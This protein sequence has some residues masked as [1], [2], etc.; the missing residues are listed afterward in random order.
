MIQ[1]SLRL[2][3][4]AWLGLGTGLAATASA[5]PAAPS[6]ASQP[7]P[8]L[9][10]AAR[11][12]A[13]L[14][15]A[16]Q[17]YIFERSA[18]SYR[19]EADGT[20][21]S[22]AEVRIR[23][24][25]ETG[26]QQLG[27]LLFTYVA[28]RN[29]LE[30][31]YLRVRRPDGSITAGS[32]DLIQ[33][34]PVPAAAQ[35]PLYSDV[36]MLHVTV[37]SFG[38]GDVLEYRLIDHLETPET[39]NR[40][41]FANAFEQQAVVLEESIEVDLPADEWINIYLAEG[42]EPEIREARG[43]RIYRWT[44][45]NETPG[46]AGAAVESLTGYDIELSNFRD[47]QEVGAWYTGLEGDRAS[48][49]REI[50]HQ[51]EVLVA[52]LTDDR[53]RIEAIYN[54]VATELRYLALL[55]GVGR[56]QPHP[57]AEV[58]DNGYGDC[59]DK[60]TL[61]AALLEA[62]GYRASPVLIGSLGEPT[63]EVPSLE[64]FDHMITAVALG[65]D[66]LLLDS[67]QSLPFGYLDPSL[68][69]KQALLMPQGEAA[70]LITVPEHL[71]FAT[72]RDF[73][74]VGE[75]DDT[76]TLSAAVEHSFRG[77]EEAY[78]RATLLALPR[79]EW[80]NLVLGLNAGM[81]LTG[82]VSEL[83][84]TEPTAIGEPLTLSYTLKRSGMLHRYR[85]NQTLDLPR[86]PIDFTAVPDDAAAAEEP[87]ELGE[88]LSA[89]SR[90]ELTLPAGFEAR[91]PVAVAIDN[92]FAAYTSRYSADGS[93]LVAER[94]AVL[95]Q[96]QLPPEHFRE[97]TALRKTAQ[98]DAEQTFNLR[99][100]QGAPVAAEA[101]DAAALH[102]AATSAAKAGD[103][104][105]A[106]ELFSRLVELEPE[107]ATAW[108]DLG[109][110]LVLAGEVEK[111]VGA[112]RRQIE[113]DP[114]HERVHSN[115]GWALE[116]A[117]DP[118]AAEAA[119][120]AQL[121]RYPLNHYANAHLGELLDEQERCADAVP[122]LENALSIESDDHE[123]RMRLG[124][125]Q[126]RL[127]RRQEGVATL[128]PLAASSEVWA[129]HSAGYEALEHDAVDTA[130]RLLRRAIELDPD[131]DFAFNNLGRALLHQGRFD[132]AEAALRRQIEIVPTDRW[133]HLNLAR[134]LVQQGKLPPAIA[135]ARRHLEIVPDDT[136]ALSGLA[137]ALWG[138]RQ[139]DEAT[140]TLRRLLELEPEHPV[141]YTM[142]GN[143][144]FETNDF[145]EAA[146]ALEKALALNAED[147]P[148]NNML[149]I[150]YARQERYTEA[151]PLLEKARALMGE[152][153]TDQDMLDHVREKAGSE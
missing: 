115:L 132:E 58:L 53:A 18:R 8:E 49:T 145:D 17:P 33:D 141:A 65:D 47:W 3:T 153:F 90:I 125:C 86:P 44:G 66:R 40:Y 85:Q 43:R 130:I 2:L 143:I 62:A 103:H 39:P 138:N 54:Y 152:H 24:H 109:R 21:R 30:L 124:R 36:R 87:M 111:G 112:F 134:S 14:A 13:E 77:D 63:E 129:V 102:E 35:F 93:K 31:D 50:R 52:G 136:E 73:S 22:V 61:L 27:Q 144:L 150:I 118:Q 78:L 5:Q 84:I 107:H 121:E 108:H 32:A 126:L 74:L 106:V 88:L 46:G 148:A 113:G 135:A 25:N 34:L 105:T 117:G 75:I 28:G 97:W 100:S 64:G 149:G 104:A 11:V 114:F 4:I 133:A 140:G 16:S 9:A 29:R 10:D 12:Q 146:G 99:R 6:H 116:K 60:H 96:H 56:Y 7:G 57:A 137:M 89:Q 95:K 15:H 48:P 71:P 69:G 68:R 72:R 139:L 26:V 23:V 127:G 82:E 123:S 45:A 92:D 131:H 19:F 83:E 119:Y 98:A 81:G 20:G 76:G 122:Y 70:R 142:L 110:A 38:P 41:W 101:T 80:Q 55:F 128:E 94:E 59:K 67:S 1:I 120:R 51:A 37:P 151:L 91:A 42:R 79:P 147:P